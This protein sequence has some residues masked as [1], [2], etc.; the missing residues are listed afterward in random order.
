MKK[1]SRARR[2]AAL[3]LTAAMVFG[4]VQVPGL[5]HEAHAATG[6]LS[7][8]TM[9]Y[10]DAKSLIKMSAGP[11]GDVSKAGRIKLGK[12]STGAVMD[13]IVLGEDNHVDGDNI[14]VFAG[15]DLMAPGTQKFHDN[16]DLITWDDAYGT[17]TGGYTPEKVWPNHYGASA[18]RKALIAYAD[19]D[20][21]SDAEKLLLQA[22]TVDTPDYKGSGDDERLTNPKVYYTTDKIYAAWGDPKC[23]QTTGDDYTIARD[24]TYIYIGADRDKRINKNS[25]GQRARNWLRTPIA[26]VNGSY[27][28]RYPVWGTATDENIDDGTEVNR[29]NAVRPATNISLDNALFA[30]AAQASSD[31]TAT[32]AKIKTAD[33]SKY[34][35]KEAMSLRLDPK[36]PLGGGAEVK[37]GELTCDTASGTVN[38]AKYPAATGTV[39]LIVQGAYDGTDWYYSTQVADKVSVTVNEIAQ[40]LADKSVF[41]EGVAADVIAGY[42]DLAECAAWLETPVDEAG[43]LFYASSAHVHK[44]DEAKSAFKVDATYHWKE[45]INIPCPDEEGA[46]TG[47]EWYGEHDYTDVDYSHDDDYH[48]KKCKICDSD[49]VE[50]MKDRAAHELDADGK[51]TVCSYDMNKEH[52]FDKHVSANDASCTAAGNKEYWECTDDGCEVKYYIVLGLPIQFTVVS[53]SNVVIPKTP[54]TLGAYSSDSSSHWQECSVCHERLNEAAHTFSGNKCTVCG[55]TKS[56]SSS[57]NSERGSSSGSSG[58]G[59]GS[60]S[61]ATGTSIIGAGNTSGAWVKDNTGWRYRY[62]GG[63]YATGTNLNGADGKAIEKI[64]W[65]KINNADY[66]FGSDTYLR[67]GWVYDNTDSKWYYC[68]VNKG[69]V[70]GW[71]YD[72]EDR[73][74]YYLDA[75][76]G[77]MLTGWQLIGGKQYYFAPA[78]AAATYAF[79]ASSSRW[80]YSNAANHRPYG[81]MYAGTTTP[82]NHSVDASGARIS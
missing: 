46:K 26:I 48:Y 6:D 5:M 40:V 3:V 11:T 17:Y 73:Y 60:A 16:T 38:A 7:L 65:I 29:P 58:G 36:K 27:C 54:H 13:W 37:V 10:A 71:F 4:L 52:N 24:M 12:D 72:T 76:T 25:I 22:T 8:S 30:S 59:G 47:S 18:L 23:A 45:C 28:A 14:A 2:A 75:N 19:S 57:R 33:V 44:Y 78:P 50:S 62:S 82:D 80:V 63:T 34:N 20:K 35:T 15:K 32:A 21:F 41:G 70:Y 39:S 67:T 77:A 64:A 69:R 51:C 66:A 68:D 43:T 74:W 55:Y 31:G 81:S 61:S 1:I 9:A 49:V 42:I 56:G 79:D 53:E